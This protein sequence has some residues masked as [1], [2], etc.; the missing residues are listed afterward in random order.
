M[1]VL[2]LI[3]KGKTPD[4]T[5]LRQTTGRAAWGCLRERMPTAAELRQ[6]FGMPT[7]AGCR[8]NIGIITGGPSGLVVLDFDVD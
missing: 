4:L 6:W 3:P 8:R 1:S 7:A 2:P 5:A